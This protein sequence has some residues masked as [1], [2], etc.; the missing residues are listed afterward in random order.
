MADYT[1]TRF[2]QRDGRAWVRV[3]DQLPMYHRYLHFGTSIQGVLNLNDVSTPVLEYIGLMVQLGKT[4]VP[5]PE[6]SLVGGLGACAIW[7]ALRSWRGPRNPI[8]VIESCEL[9]LDLATRFFR[10]PLKEL[11]EP[12]K[13][14][15]RL[16]KETARF[17]LMFIDCYNAHFMP[18][19]LMSVE[20]LRQVK[21]KLSS[22]GAAIF[23]VWNPKCNKICGHQIRTMMAVF[24]KVGVVAGKEDDNFAVCLPATPRPAMAETVTWK[25]RSYPVQWIEPDQS[26]DWP[27]YLSETRAIYDGNV[28]R[29][30][31][32][33]REV[34][35]A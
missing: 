8:E 16:V 7:H 23:N 30:M 4:T 10:F 14:R 6:N 11:P 28:W 15:E 2:E 35:T 19:D 21:A 26:H 27:D 24:G 32:E 12:Q 33:M 34:P 18:A 9:V 22:Q 1:K 20:F 5:E 31:R 25:G 3:I 13:L 17:D 29:F